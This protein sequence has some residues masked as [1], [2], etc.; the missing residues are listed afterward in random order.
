[1]SD[2]TELADLIIRVFA[3]YTDVGRVVD[4][5][6]NSNNKISRIQFTRQ[7]LRTSGILKMA[8]SY[9]AVME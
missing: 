7:K 6:I 8:I 9:I 2:P 1:M 3:C 5:A 4:P